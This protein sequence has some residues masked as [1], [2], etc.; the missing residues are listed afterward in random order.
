MAE[1]YAVSG[2]EDKFTLIREAIKSGTRRC[3]KLCDYKGWDYAE[4]SEKIQQNIIKHELAD[5]MTEE[6]LLSLQIDMQAWLDSRDSMAML[7]LDKAA[8]ILKQRLD[9]DGVK[10]KQKNIFEVVTKCNS[11]GQKKG[12]DKGYLEKWIGELVYV[13]DLDPAFNKKIDKNFLKNSAS[14][15]IAQK[16]LESMIAFPISIKDVEV[17][18]YVSEAA[19]KTLFETDPEKYLPKGACKIINAV[20]EKLKTQVIDDMII[21][22]TNIVRFVDESGHLIAQA[23]VR[24]KYTE[25]WKWIKEMCG[26]RPPHY[27]GVGLTIV[28]QELKY[29]YPALEAV[30]KKILKPGAD[31]SIRYN[32]LYDSFDERN[33]MKE[34]KANYKSEK[35]T[36]KEKDDAQKFKDEYKEQLT[37]RNL[38]KEEIMK[39][40]IA[41]VG[42]GIQLL[43]K[44]YQNPL[45]APIG[46]ERDYVR[47]Q[48]K[49]Y[50]KNCV[51]GIH[52]DGN[53][54]ATNGPSEI[55]I[56][57]LV[58]YVMSKWHSMY[59][60]NAIGYNDERDT[61]VHE[62]MKLK[63]V[64]TIS[65]YLYEKLTARLNMN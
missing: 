42:G 41:A 13:V 56:K 16:N 20:P 1:S 43:K 8:K 45:S 58:G 54:Q 22:T 63:R 23:N 25:L 44:P 36:K 24:V 49:K 14:R 53:D 30:L 2:L 12:I 28:E 34:K 50:K 47:A 65:T 21:V 60:H 61:L 4:Y 19:A 17:T 18:G 46:E 7:Y 64:D 5:L 29:V 6:F 37:R 11:E 62:E 9:K 33:L 15:K 31:I 32:A 39:I 10:Y 48:I 51:I 52:V 3:E 35:K 40:E 26:I 55:Q 27:D 57:S 59:G 38:T